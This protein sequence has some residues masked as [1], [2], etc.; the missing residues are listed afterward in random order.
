[1]SGQD[2]QTAFNLE[3]KGEV[4]CLHCKVETLYGPYRHI[5]FA[6]RYDTGESFSAGTG[7]F[8]G[9][10]IAAAGKAARQLRAE[11]HLEQVRSDLELEAATA[12]NDINN[13]YNTRQE[14]TT[15]VKALA[16]SI[17]DAIASINR[18]AQQTAESI[19]ATKRDLLTDLDKADA[20]DREL[21]EASAMLNA[22][23]APESNG[24]PA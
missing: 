18:R 3:G 8:I 16:G 4:V 1:M 6:G 7:A 11:R 15:Q 2:A 21:K 23:I 5:S 14:M 20:L 17:T 9:D 10:P 24:G 19:H 13:D 22:A 12:V